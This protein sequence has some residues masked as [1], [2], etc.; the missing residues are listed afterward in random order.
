MVYELNSTN[1]QKINLLCIGPV[2]C[3]IKETKIGLHL[4]IRAESYTN[5]IHLVAIKCNLASSYCFLQVCSSDCSDSDTKFEIFCVIPSLKLR[6]GRS[7][8]RIQRCGERWRL[9][10]SNLYCRNRH[11]LLKP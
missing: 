5:S 11:M 1:S 9:G 10:L 8:S 2:V 7:D 3:A 4:S 6:M